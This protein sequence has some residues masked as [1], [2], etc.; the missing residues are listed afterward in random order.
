MTDVEQTPAHV[1]ASTA[2]DP[3]VVRRAEPRPPR[4]GRR[5]AKVRKR[6]TVAKVLLS[7]LGVLAI[8]SGLSVVYGYRH[9]NNNI[10]QVDIED[11]FTIKHPKHV[12][13]PGPDGPLN[14]LVMGYDGRDCKGCKIDGEGGAGGSDTTILI[15]ISG[16]RSRA[17]GVSI[18]RDSLVA[19]PDCINDEGET[20]RGSSLAM[21]NAA[22]SYG[23]AACTIAQF[24]ENTDIPIDDFVVVNFASFKNM[25]DAIG[26]VEVCIPED[27][28]STE[29]GIYLKAGTRKIDGDEALAYVRVRHG[30]SDGS[31]TQR[32]KRQQAFISA[33]IN[34]VMSASTLANPVK[35]WK[36]LNAATK[37]LTT[38]EGFDADNMAGIALQL[39]GIGLDNIQFFT[40][41]SAGS[42]SQPGRVEWTS[43]AAVVWEKLLKDQPLSADLTKNAI[44][45]GNVPGV[46]SSPS[47]GATGSGS[48]TDTPSTSS[49]STGAS[50][51][52]DSSSPGYSEEEKKALE[53]AGLCA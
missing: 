36:F 14:I 24:E 37:S 1:G 48:A 26:G 10:T 6:H 51:P 27:I 53:Y 45:V 11:Q 35:V 20:I 38:N 34:Q 39:K 13:P 16:D 30:V 23:G 32:I 52:T 17:Y 28:D 3:R 41:P 18:P 9:L 50:E 40:I 7:T 19:R 46:S 25:V 12:V 49:P 15:H 5:R 42:T 4:G 29:Y 43:D 22:Y 47:A 31:D 8:L 33:M 21:W 2:A 44:N